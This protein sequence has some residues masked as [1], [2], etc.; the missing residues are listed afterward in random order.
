MRHLLVMLHLLLLLDLAL[1]LALGLLDHLLELLERE[2][3][4]K[5]ELPLL[6][7]QLLLL[8]LDDLQ[9]LPRQLPLLLQQGGKLALLLT[10]DL[11]LLVVDRVETEDRLHLGFR[12]FLSHPYCLLLSGS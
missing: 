2:V 1:L 3:L 6:V 5:L 8:L 4:L 12:F 9:L 7:L 10:H 11:L